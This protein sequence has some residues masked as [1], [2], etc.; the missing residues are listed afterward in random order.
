MSGVVVTDFESL[1]KNSELRISDVNDSLQKLRTASLELR[2]SIRNS[3][4][5]FLT[6]NL[7]YEITESSKLINKLNAYRITLRNVLKSYQYQEQRVVSAIKRFTP[8]N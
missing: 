1:I 2:R 7:Y 5:S 3:E 4:L 6:E 8:Y